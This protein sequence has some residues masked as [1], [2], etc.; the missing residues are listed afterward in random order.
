[1]KMPKNL[2]RLVTNVSFIL[3][4]LAVIVLIGGR[5]FAQ[6][7]NQVITISDPS[8]ASP[9]QVKITQL[10]TEYVESETRTLDFFEGAKCNVA[11][12]DCF[13]S[14]MQTSQVLGYT[15]LLIGT[16]SATV[17]GG[18][19]NTG[20]LIGQMGK[21]FAWTY[22][23]PA[24]GTYFVAESL[25]NLGVI[26]P[27]Y[28]QGFGYYSLTPYL[29]LWRMFRNIAYIFFTVVII[30]ISFMIL[31]R[32]KIGGQAAVTAQQ[33]LP[34]IVLA[35]IA[36]TFSYA[37][38]GFL[39]DLM[40]W[41]MYAFTTFLNFS[42]NTSANSLVNGNFGTVM[43]MVLIGDLG[44]VFGSV[45]TISEGLFAS[46]GGIVGIFK[47]VLST[48]T[49][50]LAT[51]I[52]II[53]IAVNLFRLLF[54]LLRSYAIVI[55]NIIFA[56][57]S[58]MLT[59]I[60]GSKSFQRWIM[61]IIANLSPFVI[62]FFMLV[63]NST[64]N[65]FFQAQTVSEAPLGRAIAQESERPRGFLA[66]YLIFN[67]GDYSGDKVTGSVG[68]I[69]SLGILLAMP[70]IVNN[71]KKKLGGGNEGF[72]GEIATAAGQNFR[73]QAPLGA[74]IAVG[75]AGAVGGGLLR[76]LGSGI[77]EKAKSFLDLKRSGLSIR[78]SYEGSRG[79]FRKGMGIDPDA[80]FRRGL[81]D[82]GK[83]AYRKGRSST[84][85]YSVI[86]RDLGSGNFINV[87]KS[88]FKPSVEPS[89]WHIDKYKKIVQRAEKLKDHLT[90]ARRDTGE[91][92]KWLN[93]NKSF[94][95]WLDNGAKYP[96]YLFKKKSFTADG[97]TGS[98]DG[99]KAGEEA[100]N[101][102]RTK[103]PSDDL[104]EK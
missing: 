43:N 84:I 57:F 8:L 60:P 100:N 103:L 88:V 63:I 30:A 85:K 93:E 23:P 5:I 21:I 35:L 54:L 72:F 52:I 97:A 86:G 90:S 16:P 83:S 73:K 6:N 26:S 69:V 42:G 48:L 70:E 96:S 1:M 36:V 37:I 79:A 91:V 22:Q 38:A 28:A 56:P 55:M 67:N 3:V 51:A 62:T 102:A 87:A 40:Y 49:G 15:G 29:Q 25:K 89:K 75:T 31:F 78:D 98:F 71:I 41:I 33:A 74:S 4:G 50:V 19:T 66:P 47:G 76:P 2:G 94:K 17:G 39:I 95:S 65:N 59:A 27:A 64:V 77:K 104:A 7:D 9:S 99:A 24:S 53:A 80:S 11:N 81:I 10:N 12:L 92:D 61:S 68:T 44:N 58:L 14:S 45:N 20:G 46:I 34:R 13:T 18:T 32:Q 82:Y 101:P